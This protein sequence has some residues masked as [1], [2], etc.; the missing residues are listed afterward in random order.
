MKKI[1]VVRQS[2]ELT[3]FLKT[4]R[5]RYRI[6]EFGDMTADRRDLEDVELCLVHLED[7]FNEDIEKFSKTLTSLDIPFIVYSEIET[8]KNASVAMR[9]GAADY[10]TRGTG[11]E[12]ILS[13]IDLMLEEHELC[14]LPE[15]EESEDLIVGKSSG[16]EQIFKL[17][18]KIA[19]SNV[20]VLLRGESGTGKELAARQIHLNSP[21]RNHPFVIIDCAAI[22][23]ELLEN[24]LFGHE[25][26][27]YSGAEERALGKF[28]LGDRGT[29]FIDEIAELSLDLQSKILRVLQENEFYRI[30][31]QRS[32]KVDV[33]IIVATHRNLE[34]M[35]HNG[36]FRDDL[37]HRLNVIPLHIPPLRKRLDDLPLLLGHFVR[38]YAREF[39]LPPRKISTEV[40]ERFSHYD[41]PGNIRELENRVQKLLLTER[42]PVITG[43]SIPENPEEGSR[44]L[45]ASES[46]LHRIIKE[47][48]I[49]DE[50]HWKRKNVYNEAL[51]K[52]EISLIRSVLNQTRGNQVSAARILGIS[53]NTLRIKMAELGIGSDEFK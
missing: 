11:K 50:L 20:S 16:M 40:I 46:D 41:W 6:R 47:E 18:G 30:G 52:V 35:V 48:F 23:R 44:G 51:S 2:E 8:L 21:R 25:K 9:A 29:I 36:E 32:I 34:D 43:K 28:D 7:E 26:G 27:A 5:R 1:G 39:N 22:P 49:E 45:S 15:I 24:E 42:G 53:R 37:Y 17:I 4:L 10:F 38:R 33:R 14:E 3:Q 19:A 13:A 31:G 12:A